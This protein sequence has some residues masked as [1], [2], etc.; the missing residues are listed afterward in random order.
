MPLLLNAY[1]GECIT[2]NPNPPLEPPVTLQASGGALEFSLS[3]IVD[4]TKRTIVKDRL[5][6]KIV[7]EVANSN[8]RLE[9]APSSPVV[10]LRPAKADLQEPANLAS[11]KAGAAR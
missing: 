3:Y 7:D 2:Y 1:P 5:F 10:L 4:C 11:A 8:G 9:W 6:T